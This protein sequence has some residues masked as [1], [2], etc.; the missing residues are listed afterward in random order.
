MTK[1]QAE[2]IL[3]GTCTVKDALTYMGAN[4]EDLKAAMRICSE[5]GYEA[6]DYYMRIARSKAQRL[7]DQ[8]NPKQ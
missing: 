8:L 7:I 3:C 6:V 2:H 5:E 4:D 1:P